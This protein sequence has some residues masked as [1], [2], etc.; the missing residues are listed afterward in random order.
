MSY[1]YRQYLGRG[2]IEFFKVDLWRTELAV[3]D[4]IL[5]LTKEIRVKKKEEGKRKKRTTK[6]KA[7]FICQSFLKIEEV[8]VD[9]QHKRVQIRIKR[10]IHRPLL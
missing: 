2:W 9:E 6:H 3:I 10:R 5:H 4:Y 7:V 8:K 1:E